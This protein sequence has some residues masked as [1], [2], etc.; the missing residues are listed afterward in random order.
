MFQFRFVFAVFCLTAVLLIVIY[1]RD[2]ENRVFYELCTYRAEISRLK[3]QLGTKQ[4][5]LEALIN[6]AAVSQHLN[7]LSNDN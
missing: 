3:Q 6:P 1:I 2:A 5:Q 7:E 4:L